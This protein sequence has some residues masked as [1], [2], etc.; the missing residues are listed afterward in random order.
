MEAMVL[1][2]LFKEGIRMPV[3]VPQQLPEGCRRRKDRWTPHARSGLRSLPKGSCYRQRQELFHHRF[4]TH[5]S[6]LQE[7]HCGKQMRII[8]E[9]ARSDG[10][11]HVQIRPLLHR[12]PIRITHPP[13]EMAPLSP[14]LSGV[15]TAGAR[16]LAEESPPG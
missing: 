15:T 7:D 14:R 13:A 11:R 3:T 12:Y 5:Q 16:V 9:T 6:R 4:E 10:K 2:Q 1:G 8:C